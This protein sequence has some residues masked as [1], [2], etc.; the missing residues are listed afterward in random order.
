MIQNSSLIL[1]AGT[2]LFTFIV[3]FI[4]V[5]I[6]VRKT[7]TKLKPFFVGAGIFIIFALILESIAHSFVLGS[8]NFISNNIFTYVLY[9]CLAAGLFEEAGRYVAFRFMMKENDPK[10]TAITYGLGHGGIEMILLVSL[11]LVSS[12]I[13]AMTINKLGIDEMIKGMND[14]S[15]IETVKQMIVSLNA[16]GMK[17][18]CLTII[19]RTSAMILHVSCSIFVFKAVRNKNFK[20]MLIAFGFHFVMNIPAALAQKQV[21]T[22]M[23]VV[24]LFVFVIA[25][26]SGYI[27]Y[28][29]YKEM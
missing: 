18:V 25:I 26:A 16:Y 20:Y 12:F 6:W 23:W 1:L 7:Q 9:G 21:L 29:E 19:E 10:E 24:E 11:S 3:P 17:D 2:A 13:F 14:E 28:K 22:N 27:G 8:D 4:F 15:M 5:I